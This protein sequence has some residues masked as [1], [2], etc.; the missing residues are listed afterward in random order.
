MWT[1]DQIKEKILSDNR[2]LCRGILAIYTFQTE[3]ERCSGATL[4]DNGM[5]FN[6]LDA[7]ILSSFAKQLQAGRS[8]TATQLNIA[9]KRM[10]KYSGQ[11]AKIANRG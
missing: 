5:G 1:K 4:E 3:H 9:R 2:W 6:G 11:L 7:N 8:L 10:A